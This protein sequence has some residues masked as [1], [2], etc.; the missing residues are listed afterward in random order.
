MKIL[1]LTPQFPSVVTSIK[2][3][4][5]YRTVKYLS[6]QYNIETWCFYP[7]LPP[8]FNIIRRPLKTVDIYKYWKSNIPKSDGFLPGIKKEN[9]SFISYVRLPRVLFHYLEAY[10]ILHAAKRKT[11]AIDQNYVI[12]ANWIFPAG[13][14]AYLLAKKFK[15]SYSISLLGTDVH[16]LKFGTTYWK[17]A[18]KII[19]SANYVTS[20]SE[21]LIERCRLNKI[22]IPAHKILLIDNIY[23]TDNFKILNNIK[24][25]DKYNLNK[26]KK[27]I[28]FVG[29]LVEIKNVDVLIKA[30]NEINSD[31]YIL[32][33]AGSGPE[34]SN[35]KNLASK[36][37]QSGNILFVGDLLSE[38]LI[39]YYNLADVFCLPSKNE[40]TPNVIIEALLCGLPVVATN[41]GGIPKLIRDNKNGILVPR[42][43]S[44]LLANGLK[45]ATILNWNREE[46]RNSVSRFFPE[47]A[48]KNYNKL[49]SNLYSVKN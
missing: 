4:Y 18:K 21:E 26:G 37:K 41:V 7:K 30:F 9:L 39:D 10:F 12:Y 27:I 45:K 31:N 3:I 28:L 33:I 6:R 8:L 22:D 25:R 42:N 46:L 32:I 44:K 38:A 5:L 49:F 24:L 47:H 40:G 35:L 17:F 43:N 14:L 48:V 36:T 13:H 15:V 20:V 1:W 23:D 34:E 2:G 16:D 19:E 29:G 11:K